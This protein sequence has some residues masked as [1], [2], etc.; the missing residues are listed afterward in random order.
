[1]G[2]NS[3][4]FPANMATSSSSQGQ[5]FPSLVLGEVHWGNRKGTAPFPL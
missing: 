5:C 3:K 4:T 1:M 2:L